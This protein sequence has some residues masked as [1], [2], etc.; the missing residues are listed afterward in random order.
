MGTA[1]QPYDTVCEGHTALQ[2]GDALIIR[3]GTYPE[4]ITLETPATI[5]PE[6]GSVTIGN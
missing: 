2:S 3:S 6:G 5:S 4:N 1:A